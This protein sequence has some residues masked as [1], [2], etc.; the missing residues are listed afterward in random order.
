[1]QFFLV[2]FTRALADPLLPLKEGAKRRVVFDTG[3]LQVLRL[4]IHDV[5]ACTTPRS[6]RTMQRS[7]MIQAYLPVALPPAETC[8]LLPHEGVLST[9]GRLRRP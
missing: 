8:R 4:R 3:A 9:T 2:L 5:C 7:N 1:M 6:T